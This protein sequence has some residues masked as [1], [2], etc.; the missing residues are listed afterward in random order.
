MLASDLVSQFSGNRAVVTGATGFIG[1]HLVDVLLAARARV[2]A[3]GRSKDMFNK[4]E[5]AVEYFRVD[6]TDLESLIGACT[7][8]DVVYHLVGYAHASDQVSARAELLHR[9]ITVDGTRAL[10]AAAT[11][12]GVPRFVFLSSVKVMGEGG[13]MC[14]DETAEVAPTSYYGCA[15]LEAERLVLEAGRRTGM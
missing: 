3:L 11:E 14:L 1:Q 6:L 15:K 5:G 10:L 4:Y 7:Q 2:R 9:Q 8:V 13:E 12:A